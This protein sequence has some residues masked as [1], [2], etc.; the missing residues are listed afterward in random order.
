MADYTG[1]K[2]LEIDIESAPATAFI[3]DLKTRYV[4]IKHVIER[5]YILCF[6][7]RWQHQKQI[8]FYSVWT[9]TKEEMIQAAHDLIDEADVLLH[10]NGKKYDIPILNREFLKQGLKPPTKYK[11]IDLYQVVRSTFKFMS[12]SMDSVCEE[13]GLSRKLEHKGM[14]LWAGV[15]AGKKEDQRMM[16]EYN[17]QDLE[18]LRDLYYSLQPWIT[19][20]PNRA[21]WVDDVQE[22]TCPNCESQHLHKRGIERP[23]NVNAYQ[24]YKCVDCGANSRGRVIMKRAGPGVLAK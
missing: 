1:M 6:A 9:H 5:G 19:N 13:L 24:R 20:H 11:H 14:E 18:V 4:P 10:F 22:P 7:A 12:N 8:Q 23:A 17:K 21:L 2:V 16:T 3:W 15:M